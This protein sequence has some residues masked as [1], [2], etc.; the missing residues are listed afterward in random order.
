M[1]ATA[2]DA[3]E[4]S[5]W[6]ARLHPIPDPV[7]E[8]VVVG[9]HAAFP[10]TP[11]AGTPV[12]Q[13]PGLTD[14]DKSLPAMALVRIEHA[15]VIDRVNPDG[16]HRSEWGNDPF[17]IVASGISWRLVPAE[18]DHQGRWVIAPG[19]WAAGGEEAVLPAT[20]TDHAL[21]AP[22]VVPVYDHD[23]HTGRR[24]TS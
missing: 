18:R 20:V 15:V 11:A 3:P 23:P 22:I 17:G 19:W 16:T 21:G 13:F 7:R 2:L 10:A 6:V 5:P 9:W 1:T 14:S 8:V 4:P 12:A 24:W